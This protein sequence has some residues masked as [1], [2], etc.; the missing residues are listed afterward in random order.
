MTPVLQIAIDAVKAWVDITGVDP[1]G[2]LENWTGSRQISL[3]ALHAESRLRDVIDATEID[4]TGTTTLLL[5]RPE[6][7][8]LL[9]KTAFSIVD[10]LQDF[11]ATAARVNRFRAL[12]ALLDSP[13]AV[14][15]TTMARDR[16]RATLL[17]LAGSREDSATVL[18]EADAVDLGTLRLSALQ[19]VVGGGLTLSTFAR[20]QRSGAPP[21]FLP[22]ILEVDGI[23]PLLTALAAARPPALVALALIRDP[24]TPGGAWFALG[25]RDGSAISILSD[26]SHPAHPLAAER[27]RRPDRHLDQRAGRWWFPYHLLDASPSTEIAISGA[28]ATH[29]IAALHPP[30]L[31]WLAMVLDLVRGRLFGPDAIEAAEDSYT[32][33]QIRLLGAP[34]APDATALV[35]RETLGILE[36]TPTEADDFSPESLGL[37]KEPVRPQ[38]WMEQRYGDTA[39]SA[40][41]DAVGDAT[42]LALAP[43]AG[44]SGGIALSTTTF[45]TATKVLADLRWIAR[46]NQATRVTRLAFAEYRA[47]LRTTETWIADQLAER[48]E[49]LLDTLARRTLIACSRMEL[50]DAD[51][52]NAFI[53]GRRAGGGTP[54][55]G[56]A[57]SLYIGLGPSPWAESTRW[58]RGGNPLTPTI[59][60]AIPYRWPDKNHPTKVYGFIRSTTPTGFAALLGVDVADLPVGVQASFTPK[61]YIGNPIL[62]RLDPMDCLSNPWDD[63]DTRV[64]ISATRATLAARRKSLGLPALGWPKGEL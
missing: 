22:S 39:L 32:A 45:G 47:Q 9:E 31:S 16:L 28:R 34:E 13:E 54:Y 29:A 15:A 4:P 62:D 43:R 10:I 40:G 33:P 7:E 11:E 60:P 23:A 49:F 8:A 48:R 12:L 3:G 41:V 27:T 1:D 53:R 26:H 55:E 58:Y 61:L 51:P 42:P 44:S 2:A 14:E 38:A 17:T 21:V 63:L 46:H 20:G 25:L 37:H 30:E 19:A 24:S 57:E 36:V 18:A 6:V 52:N 50:P 64:L 5:L 59:R 56:D 35:L